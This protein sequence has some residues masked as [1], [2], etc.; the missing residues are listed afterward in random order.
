MCYRILFL[1]LLDEFLLLDYLFPNSELYE[2]LKFKLF[3]Y[4]FFLLTFLLIEPYLYQLQKYHSKNTQPRHPNLS[5]H[6]KIS[7]LDSYHSQIQL[8][9]PFFVSNIMFLLAYLLCTPNFPYIV[10]Q[11]ILDMIQHPHHP[12]IPP[13]LNLNT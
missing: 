6:I 5:L 13:L 11:Q 7:Y 4:D 2:H 1:Y 10:H 12:S 3:L 8:Q 9:H